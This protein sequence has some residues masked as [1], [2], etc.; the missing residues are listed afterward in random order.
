M[1]KCE[2]GEVMTSPL[3]DAGTLTQSTQLLCFWGVSPPIGAC[4]K[5]VSEALGCVEALHFKL[6]CDRSLL[7]EKSGL[8]VIAEI[9]DQKW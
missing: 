4:T 3:F 2:C 5:K 9:K 1:G 7:K 8:D 6:K